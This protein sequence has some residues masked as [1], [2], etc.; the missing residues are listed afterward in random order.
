M[1]AGIKYLRLVCRFI[2][3]LPAQHVRAHYHEDLDAEVDYYD[4]EASIKDVFGALAGNEFLLEEVFGK[5]TNGDFHWSIVGKTLSMRY[6][7]TFTAPAIFKLS[8]ICNGIMDLADTR[9]PLGYTVRKLDSALV[10]NNPSPVYEF[11]VDDN[12]SVEDVVQKITKDAP[13]ESTL[14]WNM[15]IKRSEKDEPPSLSLTFI[16][17]KSA[18]TSSKPN[19]AKAQQAT[20][21]S[22]AAAAVKNG[23]GNKR[24][25]TAPAPVAPLPP[26]VP[27]KTQPMSI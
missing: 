13:M 2:E 5:L 14:Y 9:G 11:D 21:A 17:D 12:L 24:A 3:S 10:I 23:V 20:L 22:E 15:V 26:V 18:L 4:E 1:C 19:T 27:P 25:R 7:S 16:W 6:T 8:A